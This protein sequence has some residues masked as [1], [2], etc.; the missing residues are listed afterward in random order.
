MGDF[1]LYL[2]IAMGLV[3]AGYSVSLVAWYRSRR[4]EG[5]GRRTAKRGATPAETT[6]FLG[7]IMHG[8]A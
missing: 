7:R 8:R 2:G 3:V 1:W 6:G 4:A 5:V